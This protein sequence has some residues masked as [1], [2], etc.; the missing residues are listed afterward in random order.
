V[1]QLDGSAHVRRAR[2]EQHGPD[3]PTV[4]EISISSWPGIAACL[5][6]CLA[7]VISCRRTGRVLG[8]PGVQD[9]SRRG[10]AGFRAALLEAYRGRCAITG[11]DAAAALEGAH[12]R[13]YRGPES[14]TVTNGLL[15]SA[16]LRD[17]TPGP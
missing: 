8:S 10:Q 1:G 4:T 11:F 9:V 16:D 17:S 2:Q 15:L 13:P 12:L 6:K 3:S 5:S 14:N 7:A